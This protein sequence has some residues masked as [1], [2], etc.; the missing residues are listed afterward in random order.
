M[1]YVDDFIIISPDRCK[2]LDFVTLIQKG[3]PEFGITVNPSKTRTNFDIAS[4]EF[5]EDLFS[6]CGIRIHRES[7]D[8]RPDYSN[9]TN[10]E[11]SDHLTRD[12]AKQPGQSLCR[13]MQ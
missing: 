2:V 13:Q 5:T 3:S 4:G 1:R 8:I 12:R 6:W 11:I 7:F 10:T 9:F